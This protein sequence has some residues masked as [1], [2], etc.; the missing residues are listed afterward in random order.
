MSAADSDADG[1]GAAVEADDE[2]ADPARMVSTCTRSSFD[3]MR[4]L[5][6]RR[7][8]RVVHFFNVFAT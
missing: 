4:A 7:L 2:L 6:C 8:L 3:S 5:V 1:V